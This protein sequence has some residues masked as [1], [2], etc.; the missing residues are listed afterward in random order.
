[1][2]SLENLP[3][4]PTTPPNPRQVACADG[5]VK[6]FG[7]LGVEKSLESSGCRTHR[8]RAAEE[9]V[10]GVKGQRFG[11]GTRQLLFLRNRGILVRLS[12]VRCGNVWIWEKGWGES[13]INATC[14]TG[15]SWCHCQ[16]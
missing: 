11:C 14:A 1:M 4:L 9:S 7:A 2:P 13:V 5:R 8:T 12:E 6:L 16:R 10:D 3:S 15:A